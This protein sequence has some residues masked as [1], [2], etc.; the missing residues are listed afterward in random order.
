MGSPGKP[1]GTLEGN[2]GV[3]TTGFVPLLLSVSVVTVDAEVDDDGNEPEETDETAEP[4]EL[5]VELGATSVEEALDIL[6][7]LFYCSSSG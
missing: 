4:T 6:L 3:G 1:I 5:V 7:L 2:G